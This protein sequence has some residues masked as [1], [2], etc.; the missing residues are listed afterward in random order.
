MYIKKNNYEI[1]YCCGD[2]Q[3]REYLVLSNKCRYLN[4]DDVT[5]IGDESGV[6]DDVPIEET[7]KLI[8]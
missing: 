6:Y 3:C 8:I 5:I 2:G 1:Q 4:D 7:K